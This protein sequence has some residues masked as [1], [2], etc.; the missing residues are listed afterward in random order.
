MKRLVWIVLFFGLSLITTSVVLTVLTFIENPKGYSYPF[1][2]DADPI[3]GGFA[4]AG[5]I[6]AL[7]AFVFI[8]IE[9]GKG[10]HDSKR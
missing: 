7:Y 9:K 5:F 6:I 2:A 1:M 8:V 3:V 4:I 10:V